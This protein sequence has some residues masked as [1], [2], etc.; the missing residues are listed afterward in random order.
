MVHP[1]LRRGAGQEPVTYPDDRDSRRARKNAGRAAVSGTGDAA[2]D[3]RG[4]LHAGRPTNAAGDGSLETKRR[5]EPFR[6][7]LV[8]GMTRKATPPN[9]PTGSSDKFKA[10]ANTAFPKA[11]R[12]RSRLLVY[13]SAW[14]NAITGRVRRRVDQQPADGLLRPAQLVRDAKQHGVE[15]LAEMSGIATGTA[16]WKRP[17]V[18]TL[19]GSA[20]AWLAA[21]PDRTLKGS[22]KNVHPDRSRRSLISVNA[23]A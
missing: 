4:W 1:Y 12:P 7:K 16:R 21:S 10:S 18:G 14:I 11:T 23:P 17:T 6:Q 9:S 13:V 15:V 19:C 22:S 8:A 2:G 5:I 20:S 3:R